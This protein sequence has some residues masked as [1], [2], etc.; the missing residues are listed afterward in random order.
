MRKIALV[1]LILQAYF[2]I[3]DS[4]AQSNDSQ[5]ETFEIKYTR[6]LVNAEGGVMQ[7][8]EILAD[9]KANTTTMTPI[10][11]NFLVF[12]KY[13]QGQSRHHTFTRVGLY[14]A[15]IIMEIDNKQS[16]T[17]FFNCYLGFG[18]S[19]PNVTAEAGIDY[20]ASLFSE[21]PMIGGTIRVSQ[22]QTSLPIHV[23]Y[24]YSFEND[25]KY[26]MMGITLNYRI[27]KFPKTNSKSEFLGGFD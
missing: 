4:L 17:D 26:I 13:K 21:K 16:F 8:F 20:F 15:P 14:Y 6:L 5:L 2:P 25:A 7:G 27:M 12:R 23:K 10:G 19:K 9:K 11:L 24:F 1:L 18:V 22:G 3:D